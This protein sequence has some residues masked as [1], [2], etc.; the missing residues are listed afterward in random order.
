MSWRGGLPRP[1][2][3]A[4]EGRA[5]PTALG[6]LFFGGRASRSR[7]PRLLRRLRRQASEAADS[8]GLVPS[9][10]KRGAGGGALARGSGAIAERST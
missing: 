10:A 6:G 4:S 2:E 9:R 3:L 7:G 5:Q 1:G 8:I